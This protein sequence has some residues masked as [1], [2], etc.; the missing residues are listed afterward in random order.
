M[1]PESIH[2]R[3]SL[4]RIKPGDEGMGK[5]SLSGCPVDWVRDFGALA[6]H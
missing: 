1:T 2:R 5:V 6:G 3:E 4:A